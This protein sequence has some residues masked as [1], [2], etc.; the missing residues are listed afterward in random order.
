MDD[1]I[2][3][4]AGP[5]GSLAA[6]IL[7]RA[8]VRVRL[9]DRARFP[10]AKLC[11]DTL[12]PGA[13][14]VLAAHVP[15]A[16]IIARAIPLDGMILTGP[17][18]VA[19]RGRYTHGLQGRALPR[20]AL[21]AMLVQHA[22]AAGAAFHDQVAVLSPRR[23]A[24]GHVTGV[25][26]RGAVGQTHEHPARM[27]I[28]ADGRQSRLARAL[29]V[30]HHPAQP[31]RWA[32]GGYFEG[33]DE[34]T[35]AGE[36]HIRRGHYFGVAPM[37]GGLAN[38]CLVVPYESGGGAWR[39]PAQALK[40]AL[41]ADARLA[42]RF[43]RARLVGPPQVLGPMAVDATA[44]GV[45]G[46]LLAGDAAGFIDPMTGDGLRFAFSGAALAAAFTL[47]VLA[48]RVDS[49]RAASGLAAA[50]RDAFRAKW[51]FNRSLRSLVAS[52]PA[53]GV[54]A[55]GARL[56]PAAFEAIIRYAGDCHVEA[57]RAGLQAHV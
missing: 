6:L 52:P 30:L 31:R 44:A 36:M 32:I 21:D 43:A 47:D 4:G 46:L 2:I 19:V 55:I 23:D 17:G 54:A 49:E 11:G 14:R 29:K 38:G 53:V 7:S 35:S 51:R 34:L 28:A 33:V 27:V 20:T 42:P 3:V 9:F 37:P 1:V 45:P 12:N 57:P 40:A 48:G 15:I 18:E 39:D 50:R 8:G 26:L 10:R 22:V 13:L 41:T 16:P 5:A 56:L 25:L 24:K